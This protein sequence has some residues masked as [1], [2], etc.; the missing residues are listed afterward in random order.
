MPALSISRFAAA[1]GIEI[2]RIHTS[3][4]AVI[5]DLQRLAR[6]IQPATVIPIHTLEPARYV[7]Y[8]E[9]VE[10]VKDGESILL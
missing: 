4:H 6:A 5:E 9:N 3:G 1:Q 10:I 7:D 8:F 2:K